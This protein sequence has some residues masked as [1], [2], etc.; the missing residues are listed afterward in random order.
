M[1]TQCWSQHTQHGPGKCADVWSTVL[2]QQ[3][4][5][6]HPICRCNYR[7]TDSSS[8]AIHVLIVT[9]LPLCLLVQADK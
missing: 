7:A 6:R 3:S 1:G 5:Q 9:P 4:C 8:V 2:L